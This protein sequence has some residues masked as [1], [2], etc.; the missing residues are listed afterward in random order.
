[1][2]GLSAFRMNP[3]FPVNTLMIMR[4]FIAAR[5]MGV[6][7]A[8]RA[9][10]EAAM[11]EAGEKMDDPEVVA[12]VLSAAGLDARAILEATQDPDVKAGLVAHP[13]AAVERGVFGIPTFF[14]GGEMFFGK[15][16]LGQVEEEAARV[17]A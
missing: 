3:H 12:R 10:V 7:D 8:Y 13:E 14:V 6:G 9:A 5:G 11:W 16:R 2:H 15:D 17:A 4:G 1:R